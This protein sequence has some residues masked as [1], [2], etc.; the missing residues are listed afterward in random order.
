MTVYISHR[1]SSATLC[2]KVLVLKEGRVI[3]FDNHKK[4]IKNKNSL[5]YKMFMAQAEN[6]AE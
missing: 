3:D 6:Y 1:M 5:Y 2:D 4:L